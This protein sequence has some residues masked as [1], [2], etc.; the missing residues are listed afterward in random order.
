MSTS[1]KKSKETTA[2]RG[3]WHCSLSLLDE[4]HERNPDL[5]ILLVQ[6]YAEEV[7]NVHSM[8][9]NEF[10][11]QQNVSCVNCESIIQ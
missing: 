11:V 10:P 4:I 5:G 8:M 2:F 9:S 7:Q 1:S 3:T 6:Q